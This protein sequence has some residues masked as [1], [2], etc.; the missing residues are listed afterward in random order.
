M[1][2]SPSTPVAGSKR[3]REDTGVPAVDLKELIVRTEGPVDQSDAM[4][5]K[6]SKPEENE[7]CIITM[8][9]MSSYKLEFLE[10]DSSV[11][12]DLPEFRKAS[13]PCG[14]SF[15]ALALLYHF[16]RNSMA[17]PCCR[18]GSE[19]VMDLACI[20]DH[21]RR[22]F[23]AQVRKQKEADTR[24]SMADSMTTI[25]YILEQEVN[26]NLGDFLL[27]HRVFVTVYFYETMDSIRPFII[28]ELPLY[29]VETQ[30]PLR[31]ESLVSS[32]RH[33]HTNLN[34]VGIDSQAVEMVVGTR[35]LFDGV[36]ALYRTEK[37]KFLTSGNQ[38]VHG[39]IPMEGTSLSLRLS[40]A[41]NKPKLEGLTWEISKTAFMQ[42][43]IRGTFTNIHG[44]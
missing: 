9:S 19:A 23:S 7:E 27:H 41:Y 43:L 3:P 29:C 24:D 42:L 25:A 22:Q 30:G 2:S 18:E 11:F 14:H 38:R 33:I 16:A 13:L 32:I 37:F 20:P 34:M 36:V 10:S 35:S 8:E 6:I 39:T 31:F 28:S 4:I 1:S 5:V 21:L 44:I 17:C 40:S 15:H 12:E 26:H